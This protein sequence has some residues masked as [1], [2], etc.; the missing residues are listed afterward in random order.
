[1]PCI[2]KV[3]SIRE[4]VL[5]ICARCGLRDSLIN[6]TGRNSNLCLKSFRNRLS[7][8][9]SVWYHRTTGPDSGFCLGGPVEHRRRENRGAKGAELNHLFCHSR[10]NMQ[11]HIVAMLSRRRL[12]TAKCVTYYTNIRSL[13][14]RVACGAAHFRSVS[15]ID[16]ALCENVGKGRRKRTSPVRKNVLYIGSHHRPNDCLKGVVLY[17]QKRCSSR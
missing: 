10:D 15:V 17:N 7:N 3:Y 12:I 6:P 9:E 8:N 4:P 13:Y 14:P 1:M 16:H 11:E 5:R 2:S